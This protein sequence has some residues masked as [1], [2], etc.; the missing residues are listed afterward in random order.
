MIDTLV[1]VSR[2]A[3]LK[4]ISRALSK[5]GAHVYASPR[6]STTGFIR[7]EVPAANLND[8]AEVDDVLYI[9][10]DDRFY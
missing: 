1:E 2:T 10:T 3:D 7:I 9:E 8:A 6:A 5:A 4:R